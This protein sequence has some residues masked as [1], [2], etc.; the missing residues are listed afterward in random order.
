MNGI[1]VQWVTQYSKQKM[2]FTVSAGAAR[3]MQLGMSFPFIAGTNG[4]T[5]RFMS[6]PD[7]AKYIDHTILK[8]TATQETVIRFCEEAK[9]YQ[10][11]SVCVNPTH[12][13]LV[14][15]LLAGS[16]VKTCCT[17]GF[18][19]GATTTLVK[20]VETEEA[21][22]NGAQEVDMVINIGAMKDQRL[23]LVYEDIFAVVS[24]AHPHAL[25]KVIIESSDL[26]DD[27]IVA[28]C[29]LA[30]KAGADFVKTSSG[31][32]S[33]GATVEAVRLMK[34]TVGDSMLVKAS[35]GINNREICDQMLEAGAV[36][37]GTS[38][39]VLIVDGEPLTDNVTKENG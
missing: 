12:V 19:L 36:R 34:Q 4:R 21:V 8:S 16:G 17:I 27:E 23:E 13:S 9:R 32:G 26:T 7:Y 35:T 38:K 22:K 15:T 6:K 39:G 24:A 33:G 3:L 30:Q 11:A 18:P 25:V 5:E 29:I 28:A 2:V 14:H 10:F 20:T 31:F 1:V 37:M